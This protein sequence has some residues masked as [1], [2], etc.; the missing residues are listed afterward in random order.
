MTKHLTIRLSL[1]LLLLFHTATVRAWSVT[2]VA[3]ANV[4]HAYLNN[5]ASGSI[6]E[7][8]TDVTAIKLSK[9]YTR[10]LADLGLTENASGQSLYIRWY[11]ENAD[12]TLANID[13][14]LTPATTAKGHITD[15][16][17]LYWCSTLTTTPF[18]SANSAAIL[19][20][21]YVNAGTVGQKVVALIAKIDDTN[22]LTTANG[23]VTAEPAKFQLKYSF[24]LVDQT[25][26][27]A[28]Y[29]TT[30]ASHLKANQV[31]FNYKKNTT[32][33][34]LPTFD[35]DKGN[36][37]SRWYLVDRATG[38]MIENSQDYMAPAKTGWAIEG[39]FYKTPQGTT[40]YPRTD[41]TSYESN[42]HITI[43]L[44]AGKTFNDIKVVRL[45]S[46]NVTGLVY[47]NSKDVNHKYPDYFVAQDPEAWTS[48][49][50]YT[51]TYYSP[52][53]FK[54]SSGYAYNYAPEG[55]KDGRQQVAQWTYQYY[56][57]PGE[58]CK[59][60]V[61]VFKHDSNG[62]EQEPNAYW[63][64]YD[65]DTDRGSAYLSTD[66]NTGNMLFNINNSD[67]DFGL[68]C[69][70]MDTEMPNDNNV[71][72]VWF[73]TPAADTGWTGSDIACDV[74]RYVDN[75]SPTD[76]ILCEPTL[77]M[78]Y[79]FN[80][81]PATDIADNIKKASCLAIPTRTTAT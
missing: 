40:I 22:P 6:A 77:S 72:A 64:W 14:K 62:N 19:D 58:K 73:N 50:E 21:N 9:Y 46:N 81:R 27:K 32:S 66:D 51:F 54:H 8:K 34:E 71:S 31:N 45:Y 80:V 75:Q 11:I 74:S 67:S 3:D 26:A 43:T 23:A 12:G 48:V 53:D 76:D 36:Q 68:F 15:T 44:P 52:V 49:T 25:N 42:L 20:L 28:C 5:V 29:I 13:G 18:N 7:T 65:N 57:K 10:I 4:A 38:Q 47:G 33:F 30:D 56:V 79:I 1:L 17:C 78:R 61:P 59:L 39:A 69:Y 41:A 24:R 70:K 55:L 60:Y 16:Q 63:R 2:A 37:F 35:N